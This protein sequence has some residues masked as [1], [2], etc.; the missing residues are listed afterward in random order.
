MAAPK[1][2]T[3]AENA[4]KDG[5]ALL[6]L[7]LRSR[8]FINKAN[9]EEPITREEEQ[10][11]LETKS[12]ISKHQRTMVTKLPPDVSFGAERMQELLRQSISIGHLRALPKSDKQMLV[13]NWHF[14]F[15]NLSR[16]MGALQF[17]A[18]GYIPPPKV[19]KA[20]TG[21]KDMKGAASSEAKPKKKGALQKPSTYITLA[22]LG[23]I[24]YYVMNNM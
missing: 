24:A 16:A 2:P 13:T 4:L 3:P 1:P 5:Q 22:V 21:I 18:E 7:W 9:T 6:Q 19:R 20:G 10:S 14:V 15:I 8:A 11:F 23:G 12:D 17:M